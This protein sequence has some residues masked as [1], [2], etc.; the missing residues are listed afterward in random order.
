MPGK[1]PPLK[2]REIIHILKARDF[3]LDRKDKGHHYYAGYT[4]GKPRVVQ[5]DMKFEVYE[6]HWLTVVIDQS[7][8]SREE[9]YAS[10]RTTAKKINVLCAFN[11]KRRGQ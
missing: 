10:T 4:K 9:F 7:G 6:G 3:V 5:V 1:Y 11:K 8:L 2:C